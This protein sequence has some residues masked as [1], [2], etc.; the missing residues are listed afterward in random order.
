MNH[1][2][3][4]CCTTLAALAGCGT[5]AAMKPRRAVTR[6]A[7][8]YT[9]Q[10]ASRRNFGSNSL[11]GDCAENVPGWMREFS[12]AIRYAAVCAQA[13]KHRE[14]VRGV[15]YQYRTYWPS[16]FGSNSP[17]PGYTGYWMME[18]GR[19]RAAIRPSGCI[20]KPEL[21]WTASMSYCRA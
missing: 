11:C 2:T 8:M 6:N 19:K 3:T 5:E 18:S 13:E 15:T 14:A 1:V 20:L 12:P 16:N 10:Y 9:T 4:D 17:V 21:S 7:S